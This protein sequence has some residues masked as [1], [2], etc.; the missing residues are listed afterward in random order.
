DAAV[1]H[2]VAHRLAEGL[3][4]DPLVVGPAEIEEPV[5]ILEE[6]AEPATFTRGVTFGDRLQEGGAE[7]W[8]VR[9]GDQHREDHGGD[10][11]D[12]ELPVDYAGGTPEKGHRYEDRGEH[13]HDAQSAPVI[14]PMDLMVAS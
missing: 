11:G 10:D 2:Q 6:A 9:H 13:R 1:D 8:G 3:A 4:D 5:E 12:G 7:S 14:C